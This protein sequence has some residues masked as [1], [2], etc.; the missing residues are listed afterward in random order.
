MQDKLQDSVI[1]T[2]NGANVVS[3]FSHYKRLSCASHNL[4]LGTKDVIEKNP[5]EYIKSVID[6][7]KK[8]VKY[9]KHSDINN[10]LS[11][12]LKQGIRPRW[13]SIYEYIYYA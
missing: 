8:L 12:S 10:K 3:A 6:C 7:S 2:D 5:D 1:V 11:K 4:N 9:F 13:N